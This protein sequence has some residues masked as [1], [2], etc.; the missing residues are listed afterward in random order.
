MKIEHD[1]LLTKAGFYRY[2]TCNCNGTYKEKYQSLTHKDYEFH[3][4]PH[5]HF[6]FGY[7]ENRKVVK[8]WIG[9]LEKTLTSYGFIQEEKT[10]SEG[11]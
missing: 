2:Q 1:A 11:Q 10:I 3:V 5:K 9:E 6:F 4:A 7:L 8:S